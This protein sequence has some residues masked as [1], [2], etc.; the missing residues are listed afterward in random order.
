MIPSRV[1]IFMHLKA[2]IWANFH[3]F[4]VSCYFSV[5]RKNEEMSTDEIILLRVTTFPPFQQIVLKNRVKIF[6]AS[7]RKS[8]NIVL[9]FRINYT[10]ED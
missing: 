8:P 1:A 9:H 10:D 4:C 6:F 5:N 7:Q 2:N 3:S